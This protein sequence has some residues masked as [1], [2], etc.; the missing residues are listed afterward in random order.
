MKRGF[1]GSVPNDY[2]LK[3]N[4][5]GVSCKIFA[6]YSL[7][8]TTEILLC[9]SPVEVDS[10]KEGINFFRN[11]STGKDYILYK[12]KKHLKACKNL[13]KHQGGLFIKDIEDL[14]G[15]YQR[16]FAFSL[17]TLLAIRLGRKCAHPII[18][19]EPISKL[20]PRE[21]F[22]SFTLTFLGHLSD[23]EIVCFTYF[24]SLFLRILIL[25]LSLA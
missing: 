23:L 18:L 6:N 9:L 17:V 4:I 5:I 7:K 25:K 16:S 12:N 24:S 11:K 3:A 13:C 10:L 14:D 20:L 8:Q 2:P 22:V 21:N 19:N 1:E 15:R